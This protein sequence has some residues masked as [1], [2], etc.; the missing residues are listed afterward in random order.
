MR[1]HIAVKA[2][3]KYYNRKKCFTVGFALERMTRS[4]IFRTFFHA[5]F[6]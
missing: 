4:M 5:E 6:S 3:L 2:K 1:G